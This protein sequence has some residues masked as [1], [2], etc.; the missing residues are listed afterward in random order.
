MRRGR[1][2]VRHT[3]A[4]LVTADIRLWTVLALVI[5]SVLFW[6][7]ARD[8]SVSVDGV[9]YH[10][11]DD[12]QMISMRYARNLAEGHGLVWNPGGEHVEGYTNFGWTLVM[13]AI[14]RLGAGD[15]TAAFWVR[16]VNWVLAGSI[17]LLTLR[18]L[19]TLEIDRGI[20]AGAVLLTLAL[21]Y[22]FLFW[23]INGFETT[24]LTAL[25]LWG[26]L[27]ALE[28]ARLGR[29]TGR[30]LSSGRTA[31]NRAG[32]RG[33]L[34][35]CRRPHRRRSRRPPAL[36]AGGA[37]RLAACAA[38]CVPLGLLWRPAPKHLLPEG[39]GQR[40]S[41]RQRRWQHQGVR[42]RL[43]GARRAR[44]RGRRVCW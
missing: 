35:G 11:L 31:A 26:L 40:R 32:R 12:D 17:L 8:A 1:Q 15:A 5:F 42:S 30:H 10:F 18:L 29:V 13:A 4:K 28:D 19:T 20:A 9:R 43:H 44:H 24:L 34:D 39:C 2:G 3:V 38:P 36:V 14:H 41:L 33:R 27:R 21:S 6:A 25:F 16:S 7:A 37:G 23:A 22:D